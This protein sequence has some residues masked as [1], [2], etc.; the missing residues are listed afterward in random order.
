VI[1]GA[2]EFGVWQAVILRPNGEIVVARYE[3]RAL[4]DKL[5]SLG[6][7]GSDKPPGS[8]ARKPVAGSPV[9]PPAT[10]HAVRRL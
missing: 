5:E 4:L 2:G 6:A 9:R 7:A 3:L 10:Q 1:I 8:Q